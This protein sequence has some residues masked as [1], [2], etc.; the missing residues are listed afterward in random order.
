MHHRSEAPAIMVNSSHWGVLERVVV[1]GGMVDVRPFV[2][3]CGPSP[4][5]RS[6]RGCTTIWEKDTLST[7]PL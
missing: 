5:I 4:I 7:I 6:I 3:R 2:P 1:E